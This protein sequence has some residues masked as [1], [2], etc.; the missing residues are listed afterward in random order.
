VHAS[1]ISTFVLLPRGT[2]MVSSLQRG[3]TELKKYL[4][5]RMEEPAPAPV[6]SK[7]IDSNHGQSGVIGGSGEGLKAHDIHQSK[8]IDF[9]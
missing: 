5:S 4:Q 3:T 2:W 7:G 1:L 6:K 8:T 9:R